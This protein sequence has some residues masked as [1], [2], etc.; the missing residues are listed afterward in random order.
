[1]I[2]L[3]EQDNGSL[4]IVANDKELLAEYLEKFPDDREFLFEILEQSGYIGNDWHCVMNAG[5]TEAPVIGY[6]AIRDDDGGL[7]SYETIW[8]YPYYQQYHFGQSLI[9]QGFVYFSKN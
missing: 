4:K 6:G 7:D 5:L 2:T 3:V 8:Y 9:E 1:M